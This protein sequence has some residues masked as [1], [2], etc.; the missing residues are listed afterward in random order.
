MFCRAFRPLSTIR[1]CLTFFFLLSCLQLPLAVAAAHSDSAETTTKEKPPSWHRVTELGRMALL[2]G[3]FDQALEQFQT[4]LSLSQPMSTSDSRKAI[5][6]SN[7]SLIYKHKGDLNKA[8]NYSRLALKAMNAAGMKDASMFSVELNNLAGVLSEESKYAEAIELYDSSLLILA[9]AK[10][11]ASL[12]VA[13]VA[14]NL[15]S[16]HKKLKQYEDAARLEEKAVRIYQTKLGP[17]HRELAV[18]LGNLAD[19]YLN[20]GRLSEAHSASERSL[21]VMRKNFG[22]K[23]P[24]VASAMDNLA[25]IYIKEGKFAEA[26][27]LELRALDTFK[28]SLG[29]S[30]PDVAICLD[31]LSDLY[32]LQKRY[33]QAIRRAEDAL[34]V[35]ERSLGKEHA[36]TLSIKTRLNSLKEREQK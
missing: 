18:A 15:A 27:A 31:N 28:E 35:A 24:A 11:E 4:A 6:L 12:E 23:H 34:S 13:A 33:K 3:E 16:L 10:G 30:H 7:L 19:S 5:S 8:E 1:L 36:L 17:E 22:D 29:E 32:T 20:L 14:D 25:G 21:E 9:K 26:E 2:R